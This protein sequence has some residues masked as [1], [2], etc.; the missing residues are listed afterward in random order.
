MYDQQARGLVGR[1][2]KRMQCRPLGGRCG[3]I[4]EGGNLGEAELMALVSLMVTPC[5][6]VK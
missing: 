3:A 2:A 6:F 4:R 1:V 5:A